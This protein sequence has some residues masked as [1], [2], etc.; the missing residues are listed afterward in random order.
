QIGLHI[1][2]RS[3]NAP[4]FRKMTEVVPLDHLR[5][6]LKRWRRVLMA[7]NKFYDPVPAKQP[8]L[9]EDSRLL[10]IV[11]G[12]IRSPYRRWLGTRKRVGQLA[13]FMLVPCL[14]HERKIAPPL[15]WTRRYLANV[16]RAA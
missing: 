1:I 5:P 15:R 4:K 9:Q 16:R 14:L 6:G 7:P 11:N 13:A 8:H 10:S 2:H 3:Q 12:G